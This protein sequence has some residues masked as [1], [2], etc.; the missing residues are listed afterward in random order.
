MLCHIN[1]NF[2]LVTEEIARQIIDIG[3]DHMII[4]LWAA[5]EKTYSETHPN[6]PKNKFQQIIDVIKF[7]QSYKNKVPYA[8]ITFLPFRKNPESNINEMVVSFIVEIEIQSKNI[9]R[10]SGSTRANWVSNSVLSQGEWYKIS[11]SE[12]G[13]YKIDYNLLN[14]DIFRI[15]Q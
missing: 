12:S 10:S 11:V 7:I 13:V 14:S 15:K 4:S 2:T 5:S 8:N 1:T 3:V 9:S 6:Q